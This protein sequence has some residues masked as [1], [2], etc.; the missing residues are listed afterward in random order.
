MK[1]L[2]AMSLLILSLGACTTMQ[3]SA[4]IGAAA[5]AIVGGV[6]TSTVEGAAIG[7]VVGGV[8]GVLVGRVADSDDL[9]YYRTP[10]GR[11]YRDYCPDRYR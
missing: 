8:V 3:Q 11:Y 5:G 2:L 7:A 4:T 10:R 9:C 1:K 6:A